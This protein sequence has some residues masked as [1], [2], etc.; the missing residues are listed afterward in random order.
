MWLVDFML[1]GDERRGSVPQIFRIKDLIGAAT[2]MDRC[3]DYHEAYVMYVS[4]LGN[5]KKD[6]A[7][8]SSLGLFQ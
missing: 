1:Q 5:R 2:V 8:H 7:S 4:W 6:K 3:L